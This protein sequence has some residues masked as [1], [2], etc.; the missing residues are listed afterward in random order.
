M[1]KSKNS[2]VAI[3]MSVLLFTLP[4]AAATDTK[5]VNINV[6]LTPPPAP[7]VTI[8]PETWTN[9]SVTVDVSN[10]TDFGPAG[11]AKVEYS[12]DGGNSWQT[13]DTGIDFSFS[14]TDEGA[15]DI[16]VKTCDKASHISAESVK[17]AYID[18]TNPEITINGVQQGQ[19]YYEVKAPH[20]DLSDTGGSD[21]DMSSLAVTMKKDSAIIPWSNDENLT[22]K[23]SY[24]MTVTVRDSAGNTASKTVNFEINTPAAPMAP[25]VTAVSPSELRI[26]WAEA[27]GATGYRIYIDGVSQD[28]GNV[29]SY[30]N[31]DLLPNTQHTYEIEGYNA[32]GTSE[33]SPAA[34][35]WTLANKPANLHITGRAP[36]SMDFAWDTNGNPVG[37]EY[38]I[39]IE[40]GQG[41][42]DDSGFIPDLLS[43]TFTGLQLGQEYTIKVVARNCAGVEGEAETITAYANRSP[44]LTITSPT[45]GTVFS[46]LEE[47]KVIEVTGTVTDDDDDSVTVTA[48]LNGITKQ[49]IVENCLGSKPYTIS[50]DVEA[51]NIP[52]GNMTV[53]V[54]ADDGK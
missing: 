44:V 5:T 14:I 16:V 28:L 25:D 37:T 54:T 24:E 51:D 36:G 10:V 38:R 22:E 13:D 17:H 18:K 30:H 53:T 26:D 40:D 41:Y 20:Y 52:E 2:I 21:I 12:T 50:F 23:G 8:N 31:T 7:G 47:Y 4:A 3:L 9:G 46:E 34:I 42:S 43:H 39:S 48:M 32:L 27:T 11:V 1:G 49:V 29:T 33:K 6:D 45:D 35:G 15:H 19:V